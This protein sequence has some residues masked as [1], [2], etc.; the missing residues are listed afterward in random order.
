MELNDSKQL[1]I[2]V[3]VMYI[4]V[5]CLCLSCW[6]DW[7][8]GLIWAFA[9]PALAIIVFN[10]GMFIKALLISKRTMAKKQGGEDKSHIMTL[11]KGND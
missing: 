11:L 6:L 4:K 5:S 1:M 9:G 2:L 7:S 8:N 3:I 10:T